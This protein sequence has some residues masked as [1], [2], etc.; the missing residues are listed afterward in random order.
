MDA[1]R[2]AGDEAFKRRVEAQWGLIRSGQEAIPFA[3]RMLGSSDPE[4]REDG[5]G[6]L[7][8]LGTQDGV[9][10][11]VLA[12]LAAESDDQAR[13]SLVLALGELGD[14]RAIPALAGLIRAEDTD[15]DTRFT[16]VQSLGRLAKRRFDNQED[17]VGAA[18]VWLDEKAR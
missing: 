13:D 16:A 11:G 1:G 12:A 4:I 15:G 14:Q 7:G 17:P 10:D 9:A 18:I 2:I 5:G 8:Q 3:L 6:I